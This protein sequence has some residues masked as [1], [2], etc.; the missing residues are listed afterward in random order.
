[1]RRWCG[2]LEEEIS[3]WPDVTSKSMFGMA[4]FYCGPRI[5]AAVPRTRAARTEWSV[6][7]KLP[8]FK[9]K[10][11]KAGSGPGAGWVTFELEEEGDISAAL[12]WIGKAYEKARK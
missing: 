2:L 8:G 11:L 10:R 4:S 6:L 7:I 5:F 3:S 9:H 1:M 12:Q